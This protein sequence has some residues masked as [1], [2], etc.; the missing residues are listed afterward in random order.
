MIACGCGCCCGAWGKL[1]LAVVKLALLLLVKLAVVALLLLVKLAV[2]ALLLLAATE[3]RGS[4]AL[5]FQR[6]FLFFLA[7]LTAAARTRRS[8]LIG[9]EMG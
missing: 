3:K 5:E 9:V 2:V 1:E 6:V 4:L 7:V 8:I